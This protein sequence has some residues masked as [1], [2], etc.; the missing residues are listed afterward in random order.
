MRRKGFTFIEMM[1]VMSIFLIML[2]AGVMSYESMIHESDMRA[3]QTLSRA[4][5][6]S[7]KE[8]AITKSRAVRVDVLGTTTNDVFFMTDDATGNPIGQEG[9]CN[10]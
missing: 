6:H 5:M 2:G 4:I 7:A 1:V 3:A 9:G 10:Y 8:H